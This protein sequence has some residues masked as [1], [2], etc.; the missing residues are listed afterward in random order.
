ML[1]REHLHFILDDDGV[2]AVELGQVIK[3][4]SR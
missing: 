3:A 4:L 2:E 1:D